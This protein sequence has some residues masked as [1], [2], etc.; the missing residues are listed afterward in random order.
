MVALKLKSLL[1]G[2]AISTTIVSALPC[3]QFDTS[4]NLYAFGGS[5]DVKLGSNTT[6]ARECFSTFEGYPRCVSLIDM[7]ADCGGRAKR[8][9]FDDNWTT[10]SV[11][12][13]E[14]VWRF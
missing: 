10:V 4:Y 11:S 3:V 7:A 5:E 1:I 6:W 2:S 9:P 8:Y 14:S 13:G 12:R